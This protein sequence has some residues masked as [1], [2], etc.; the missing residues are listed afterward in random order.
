[1]K[2]L[3]FEELKECTQELY[4]ILAD[5]QMES[6]DLGL[7]KTIVRICE[8]KCMRLCANIITHPIKL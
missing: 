5:D 1:M 3:F 8:M 4:E 6:G 7:I 2:A